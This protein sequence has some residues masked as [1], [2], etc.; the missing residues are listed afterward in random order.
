MREAFKR[1]A[2]V[3]T[4]VQAILSKFAASL[5]RDRIEAVSVPKF[6]SVDPSNLRHGWSRYDVARSPAS[7][8][9]ADLRHNIRSRCTLGHIEP[10]LGGFL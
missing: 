7:K 2:S 3:L 5:K 4:R 10:P 6:E 9:T 8:S 1:L